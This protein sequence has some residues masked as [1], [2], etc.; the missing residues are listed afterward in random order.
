MPPI[1]AGHASRAARR[2]PH[3]HLGLG[4]LE[5]CIKARGLRDGARL[6]QAQLLDVAVAGGWGLG[7]SATNKWSS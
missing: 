7:V 6:D 2:G 4:K 5:G 1:S 3:T